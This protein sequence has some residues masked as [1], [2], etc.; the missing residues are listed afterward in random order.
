MLQDRITSRESGILTYGITPPKA[1]LEAS[2]ICEIA[3]QQFARISKLAVDALIVYDLQD[4]SD[5]NHE[6]RPFPFI[7]T[8]DASE[9]YDAHFTKLDIPG[10]VY[11]CVGKYSAKN[12]AS[13]IAKDAGKDRYSVFVGASSSTQTVRLGLSDAYRLALHRNPHFHLGGVAIPERHMLRQDEHLRVLDKMEKGC[14][15]FVSQAVYNLDSAKNFLSDYYYACQEKGI[16]PVPILFTITPCGSLKTLQFMQWLGISIPKWM[17]ND[18][19]HS[20]DMLEKSVDLSVS[21]FKELW[22]FALE[23]NIPIGC[24]VESVSVRKEE[25][26]ASVILVERIRKIMSDAPMA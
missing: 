7:K 14:S 19:L 15:F 6:D 17:E 4:E 23:K 3:A 20:V 24:N 18:M 10:I 9:Y 26:D 22:A 13:W 16:L 11:R 25:I 12:L 2:R 8:L 5:R 1:G 21:N